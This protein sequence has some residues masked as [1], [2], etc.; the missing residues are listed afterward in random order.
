MTLIYIKTKISLPHLTRIYNIC[1]YWIIIKKFNFL[2]K[3]QNHFKTYLYIQSTSESSTLEG[4]KCKFVLIN[5]DNS[6]HPE[7]ININSDLFL[8]QT[9]SRE[10]VQKINKFPHITLLRR[11]HVMG[12]C[13]IKSPSIILSILRCQ[14]NH[15][16]TPGDESIFAGIHLKFVLFYYTYT[17]NKYTRLT[18]V[19]VWIFFIERFRV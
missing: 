17:I 10:M 4:R 19:R 15:T 7:T 5:S 18:C 1:I 16:S 9:K 14:S 11:V 13:E 6:S 12:S 3:T 8:T 2:N